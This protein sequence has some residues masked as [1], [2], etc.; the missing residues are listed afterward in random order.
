MFKVQELPVIAG[1]GNIEPPRQCNARGAGLDFC[2]THY[3]NQRVCC[4]DLHQ[5]RAA[6]A[7]PDDRDMRGVR[8]SGFAESSGRYSLG[9]RH[10]GAYSLGSR[11]LLCPDEWR[12]ERERKRKQEGPC[13]LTAHVVAGLTF[14]ARP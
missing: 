9:S 3:L 12:E 5:R 13:P 2:H 6:A 1:H 10:L 14:S 8:C 4:E 11:T 7:C